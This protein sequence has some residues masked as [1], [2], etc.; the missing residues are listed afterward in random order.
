MHLK[1]SGT[2]EINNAVKKEKPCFKLF[3]SKKTGVSLD[4]ESRLSIIIKES[5][6]SVKV[7]LQNQFTNHFNFYLTQA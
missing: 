1:H 3:F 7:N 6:T 5:N 4:S 2:F